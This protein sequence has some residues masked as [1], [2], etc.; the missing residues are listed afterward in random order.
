[1]TTNRRELEIRVAEVSRALHRMGWVANHDGNVSVRLDEGRFLA[2]PTAVSK[3]AITRES[4]IVVDERG[5]LV[6]GQGKPFTEMS[7]HLAVFRA[8]SDVQ[9]V[10]HA[11]PPTATGFAVAGSSIKTTMLAESVVSLGATVPLVAY[12]RPKTPEWTQNLLAHLDEADALLL[13]H[14]GVLTYGPDVETA[15]LRMELVEHL[16]K[17]Q[18]AAEQAGQTRDIPAAD[19]AKLLE[20]RTAAGLGRVARAKAAG[21]SV[22]VL[23][24][25]PS[26]SAGDAR[27]KAMVLEEV[28][29]A[30]GRS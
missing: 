14:H 24:P 15:Y 12:A 16:A 29:R 5:A 28:G 2:T 4:L 18:L 6:S 26:V 9:A 7:L 30:L 8:R 13:E 10:V 19:V 11:H 21:T 23:T 22:A 17:I 20:A 25:T 1:M 3:A 27:L